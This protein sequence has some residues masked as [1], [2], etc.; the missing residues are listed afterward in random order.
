MIS[1]RVLKINRRNKDFSQIPTC[2]TDK[3]QKDL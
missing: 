3:K 1:Q 2:F